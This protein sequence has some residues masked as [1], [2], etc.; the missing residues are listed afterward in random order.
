M[1]ENLVQIKN[2]KTYFYT[3]DGIVK[4]VDDV[5][6]N[7]RKGEI[8][9][10]VGESGCGKSVTAMSIMR[11]IPSPPGKIVGG[12]II[13]EGENILNIKEDNMRKIRGNDIAVIFQEPM[14]SLNPIF[15]IGYQI[16][17]VIL[18]HQKTSKIEAKKKAVEM[19]KLVGVPRADEIV[20]CYPH[21]LSGGM[22]QRAMIAM[23]VSCNPKLL[24]ADEP[25][26]ALDVTIQAQILDIMRDLKKKTSTSIMLITH[27]L[28]VI[29]EMAEYVVVMYAGNIIEEAP[30][31]ELFKNP[32][33]P[34][35]DGLM[36]SKPSLDKEVDRLY[37]IPGQVPNPI[38]MPE[39]C[40]FCTRCPKVMDIC[41]KQQPPTR[42]ITPGHKV[43]CFLYEGQG[44]DVSARSNS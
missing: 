4:A 18:L 44:G 7:I 26:T 1:S 6:F 21:E 24:I 35:T 28:G 31:M 10:V 30:V 12:E 27:D 32:M 36:K 33:H 11:L 5:T 17:E 3:G 37:S 16:E 42:E 2:L 38:D 25:T 23:A 13:F 14:T 8:L 34:Y 43:A 41:R 19:L 29:A 39:E 15:T 22:R 9:G 40:H 20:A